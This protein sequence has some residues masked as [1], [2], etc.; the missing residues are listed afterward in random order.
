MKYATHIVVKIYNYNHNIA[1][2]ISH[3]QRIFHNFRY[4]TY[5]I[6]INF[7]ST[8][9]SRKNASLARRKAFFITYRNIVYR[10]AGTRG[11]RKILRKP[12]AN[13]PVRE[14]SYSSRKRV[15]VPRRAWKS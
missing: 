8:T 11:A 1:F 7:I 4:F 3:I 14:E 10:P 13:I 5:A 9:R 2:A 6:G 15:R 12:L